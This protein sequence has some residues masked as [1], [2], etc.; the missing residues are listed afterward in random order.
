MCK[1]Q[2]IVIVAESGA[3]ISDE[4]VER[5][6][7]YIV[8]MYV[9][10][11]E[12][13]CKDGS[14]PVTELYQY[15]EKTGTLPKTS[16]PNPADYREIFETIHETFPRAEILHLCYSAVTSCSYQNA[17]LASEDL[18]F[19]THIDA[20]SVT[21]GQAALVLRTARYIENHPDITVEKLLPVVQGWI[22]QS[23]MVFIPENL[24]YLRAGGRVSNAAYLGA[25]LLSIKPLIEILDGKLVSTKKYRGKMERVI[26]RLIMDF[27]EKYDPVRDEIYVI[28]SEGFEHQLGHLIEEQLRKYGVNDPVWI[29]TGTVITTHGGPGAFGLAAFRNASNVKDS[30]TGKRFFAVSSK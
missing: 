18:P 15:Y 23:C 27:F 25:S 14:F 9:T 11:G 4:Y 17:V 7:L 26:E 1:V 10:M 29:K 28:W 21:A 12:K 20:K 3:D 16:A 6:G 13:T 19:V 24:E 2:K 30:F 5:Y 22:E 8:P